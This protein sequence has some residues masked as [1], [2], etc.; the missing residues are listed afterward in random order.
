[1][2]NGN[3]KIFSY[4][5]LY[6]QVANVEERLNEKMKCIE[7]KFELFKNNDMKEI[8]KNITGLQVQTGKMEV[9][10]GNLKAIGWAIFVALMGNLAMLILGW[11]KVKP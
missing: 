8:L 11:L 7:D 3:G 10:M 9:K 5:D 6:E 4:H 1:M 2:A